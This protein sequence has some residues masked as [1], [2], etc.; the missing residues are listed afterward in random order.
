MAN[1]TSPP[2]DN[3]HIFLSYDE[4][5]PEE[6]FNNLISTIDSSGIKFVKESRVH[7]PFAGVELFLPTAIDRKSVV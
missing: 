5:I 4:N 2:T 6:T 1:N 3:H 7:G